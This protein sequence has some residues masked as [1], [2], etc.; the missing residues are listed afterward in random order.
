MWDLFVGKIGLPF[1]RQLN[2]FNPK[3]K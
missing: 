3:E 1:A 2:L